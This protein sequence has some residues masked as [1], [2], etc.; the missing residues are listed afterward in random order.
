MSELLAIQ[1]SILSHIT[2]YY[3]FREVFWNYYGKTNVH[4]YAATLVFYWI[5][6]AYPITF[7]LYIRLIYLLRKWKRTNLII[8]EDWMQK[9][10]NLDED[11]WQDSN[12]SYERRI[13]YN[14]L[15]LLPHIYVFSIVF[16]SCLYCLL[17]VDTNH[18]GQFPHSN[19]DATINEYSKQKKINP[20]YKLWHA[21]T[22]ADYRSAI[23][24]NND[25]KATWD[26]RIRSRYMIIVYENRD[27]IPARFALCFYPTL[28]PNKRTGNL[29]TYYYSFDDNAGSIHDAKRAIGYAGIVEPPDDYIDA[30]LLDP[31]KWRIYGIND[32]SDLTELDE[33]SL[34]YADEQILELVL[35]ILFILYLFTVVQKIK[36]FSIQRKI[37]RENPSLE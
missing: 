34:P 35:G 23:K 9:Q 26:D 29:L 33:A 31:A 18:E 2:I 6:I 12:I 11:G 3:Y 14:N 30:D 19:V 28:K 25:I 32:D 21:I 1:F 15:F 8:N 13:A 36:R 22:Q 37:K 20:G 4:P 16:G 5:Y 7:F 24:E 10:Y 17:Y 27:A